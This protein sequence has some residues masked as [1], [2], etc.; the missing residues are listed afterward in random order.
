M[1]DQNISPLT[2]KFVRQLGHDAV[3]TRILS[4]AEADDDLLW[5]LCLSED[6]TLIT[7]DK[8]FGDIR[9]YPVQRG[10]GIILLRTRSTHS[11]KVN[12]LL[13]TLFTQFKEEVIT[14]S[15][16]ILTET[17]IRIKQP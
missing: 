11:M 9:D 2:T 8:D 3:D 14:S 13:E 5:A 10:S 16:I 1:L 15:L 12:H 4:L 7:F 17:K 6:R